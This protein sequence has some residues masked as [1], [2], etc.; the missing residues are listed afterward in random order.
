MH[1]YRFLALVVIIAWLFP[2]A[3]DPPPTPAPAEV[4]VELAEAF[5]RRL[6]AAPGARSLAF[7]LFS[8][9]VDTALVSPDGETAVLWLA[10]RDDSGRILATEPGLAL[11]RRT[12]AGWQVLLP[13]DPAWDEVFAAVPENLLPLEHRPAPR[14]LEFS[15][16]SAAALTGYY[17]PWAAGTAH[18]LEGSISHFQSVPE[19]GY[20]SCGIDTCRYAYDFTDQAPFPLLASKDGIVHASRDICADGSTTCTNYIVLR[21][22]SGATYQIYL[23]LAQGTIPDKLKPGT[24][25][26]RGQYIG[27]SDDTGYSTSQHVHFMVVDS[28]WPGGDGYYWGRS[29][30]IRFVD[31]PVNNGIPRNCY[32]VTRFPIYDGARDCLGDKSDPRNPANDWYVSGN[33]GAFPPEGELTRPISGAVVTVGS[34][35]VLD[36]TAQASDDVRVTALRL[37][38][39]VN[40]QWVE[41]GPKVSGKT[42]STQYDWDV[43]LC[44]AGAFHGPLEVALRVWDYEGN[45]SSALSPRTIRVDHACPPPSS[46]LRPAA[47]FDSTAVRLNWTASS[48]AGFNRFELQWRAAGEAWKDSQM[49]SIPGGRRSTWFT[50]EPGKRYEYRLRAVDING[51][52]EAWPAGVE[53]SASLPSTCTADAFEPDDSPAQAFTLPVSVPAQRSL[54]GRGNSDWFKVNI[55]EGGDYLVRAV[56]HNGGAAVKISVFGPDGKTVIASGQAGGTGQHA[57]V[58]FRAV[59]GRS[60]F[61]RIDP[62]LAD[63]FGTQ[64]EYILSVSQRA[65]YLPLVER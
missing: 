13:G 24:F 20:P 25:V 63:L 7:E 18:W 59:S 22:T 48:R 56:S 57:S 52:T 32:E 55:E 1:A 4:E 62:L 8:P 31:V 3:Q 33:V 38:A 43:D 40:G 51:Q 45:V 46:E 41:I 30:D 10:L 36:V 58:S 35:T 15:P 44:A 39:R 50:G 2:A 9:E 26:R 28:L 53:T 5:S 54:C 34:G 23:H 65:I 6:S 27:D 37:V 14:S 49:I 64:A 11:A 47:T 42:G 19:L 61:I 12:D 60:Y 21:D 29:V 16:S 17:L